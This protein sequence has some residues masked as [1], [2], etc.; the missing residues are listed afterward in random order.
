MFACL[1]FT[2]AIPLVHFAITDTG[3]AGYSFQSQFPYYAAMAA[4]YLYF[5]FNY[6]RIGLY[7]YSVRFPEKH[8][9]GKFDNCG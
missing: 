8:L 6:I 3:L 4:S 5:I 7:I 9:P 2:S 1:G